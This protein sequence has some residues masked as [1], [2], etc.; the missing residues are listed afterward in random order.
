MDNRDLSPGAEAAEASATESA[1]QEGAIADIPGGQV[2][3]G[4]SKTQELLRG[5]ME[6][7]RKHPELALGLKIAAIAGGMAVAEGE[8]RADNKKPQPVVIDTRDSDA[9]RDSQ[10]YKIPSTV[11]ADA[12]KDVKPEDRSQ[13]V[14]EG[15]QLENAIKA[16]KKAL[17][18]DTGKPAADDTTDDSMR[19]S[20]L[21]DAGVS[22]DSQLQRCIGLALARKKNVSDLYNLGGI[23]PQMVRDGVMAYKKRLVKEA[24]RPHVERLGGVGRAAKEATR[25]GTSDPGDNDPLGREFKKK[26]D[27]LFQQ[28]KK[29]TPR[30]VK[31]VRQA[32]DSERPKG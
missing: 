24:A 28:D 12:L 29:P 23:P 1:R 27:Y 6:W 25:S 13:V 5:L 17:A 21:G 19:R 14:E 3:E 10:D 20:A 22:L 4:P 11:K 2:E 32:G 15:I 9:A 30:G 18:S 31:K 16:Y 8:L 7:A 26:F